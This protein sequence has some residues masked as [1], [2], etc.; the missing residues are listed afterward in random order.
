MRGRKNITTLPI[1]LLAAAT[2][3]RSPDNLTA[4]WVS[5]LEDVHYQKLVAVGLAQQ[6]QSLE[7]GPWLESYLAGHTGLKPGSKTALEL[8]RRS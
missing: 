3:R 6:R 4:T 2:L 8:T 5:S 7:L 1:E